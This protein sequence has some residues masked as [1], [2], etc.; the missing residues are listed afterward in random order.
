[1]NLSQIVQA[2]KAPKLQKLTPSKVTADL[3]KATGFKA[4]FRHPKL[5]RIRSGL[6]ATKYNPWIILVQ[7]ELH[8]DEA[9]PGA[10]EW[11]ELFNPRW[12]ALLD[13]AIKAGYTLVADVASSS[14]VFGGPEAYRIALEKG[15][16][17]L[18][19]PA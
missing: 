3:K 13:G 9:E 19:K 15:I 16:V 5:G 18:A 2:A 12:K 8:S 10:R 1:M 11:E 17:A 4:S 14:R 7:Y 6:K